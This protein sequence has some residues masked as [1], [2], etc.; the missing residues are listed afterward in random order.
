[1]VDVTFVRCGLH[2]MGLYLDDS[3]DLNVALAFTKR[4]VLRKLA[5]KNDSVRF[6]L[7]K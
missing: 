1:M 2:A 7:A 4:G 3:G 6:V 5:S